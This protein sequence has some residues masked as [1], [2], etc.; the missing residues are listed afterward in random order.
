MS[1]PSTLQKLDD[2]RAFMLKHGNIPAPSD[3][4]IAPHWEMC[5]AHAMLLL[6]LRNIYEVACVHS[7]DCEGFKLI[8]GFTSLESSNHCGSRLSR[9]HVILSVLGCSA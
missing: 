6:G 4:F 3:P 1:A 8:G 5:G 2:A 7:L 9:L